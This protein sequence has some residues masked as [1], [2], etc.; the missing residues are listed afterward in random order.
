MKIEIV[1][2]NTHCALYR[3][4]RPMIAADFIQLRDLGVK[5]ILNLERGWFDFFHNQ[6]NWEFDQATELGIDGWHLQMGDLTRPKPD[7]LRAA[8]I[9][10]QN[11]FNNG[12]VYVHCLH[13][14][15]RTGIVCAA[16]RVKVKKWSVEKAINEMYAMGFHRFPYEMLGWVKML[17]KFCGGA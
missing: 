10:I 12:S 6:M 1:T 14:V 7:D 3:G 2:G 11:A 15:D 8:I 17:R 16:F 9:G 5:T 13:G 4:P